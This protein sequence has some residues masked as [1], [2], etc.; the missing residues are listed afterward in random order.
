M[1]QIPKKITVFFFKSDTAKMPVRDWLLGLPAEDRRII[2]EDIKT[3]EF[4]WPVGMPVVR[5]LGDKL[6][7]VRSVL[8]NGDESRIIFTRF[9]S[10]MVLLHGFVKKTKKIRQHD[11]DLAKNRMRKFLHGAQ[12]KILRG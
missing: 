3:A 5:S 4:G 11:L 2:G 10:L 9:K 6:Y 1:T 8:T 12:T 7:E